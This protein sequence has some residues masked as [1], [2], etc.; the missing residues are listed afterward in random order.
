M[1]QAILIEKDEFDR[2][3]VELLSALKELKTSSIQPQWLRSKDVRKMLG[4]SDATL[5][6]L[7]VNCT[8]PSYKLGSSWYYKYDEITAALES[9]R[10]GREDSEL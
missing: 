6:T 7:R 5:Q 1:A 4:I 2:L 10:T 8:I 3:K 9:N